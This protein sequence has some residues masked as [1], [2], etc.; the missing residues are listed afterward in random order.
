MERVSA[1]AQKKGESLEVNLHQG[2]QPLGKQYLVKRAQLVL[3]PTTNS[4]VK[5]LCVL[6]SGLV[7]IIFILISKTSLKRHALPKSDRMHVPKTHE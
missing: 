7:S 2:K 6:C 5:Q 3:L 1:K 4:D